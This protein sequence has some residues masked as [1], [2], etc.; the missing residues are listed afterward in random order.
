MASS[1]I[2]VEKLVITFLVDNTIE[3]MSKLPPGFT[4]EMRQHLVD[5]KPVIDPL[6]GVPI[7]D[8]ENF[9]CGAHGFSALIVR[10]L[11]LFDTGP[12]SKS[13]VRNIASMQV[14]VD[15]ISRIVLSHWHSDHSG[16]LLSYLALRSTPVVVDVHPVR[17]VARGIAP[18]GQGGKVLC[19]IPADPTF[20]EMEARNAVIEKHTEGHAV[21][22]GTVYVSG[23]IP[24]V[25]SFETGLLGAVTWS[26]EQGSWFQDEQI[27]DERYAAI[28]VLGKGLVIFSA[29]SHA[30]IVNVC[31]DALAKF[32]RPI[33][34]VI[35][36]L[37]LAGPEL[38]SR[39]AP[40][41]KFISR[42]LR[43]A[44]MYVLPMH[45]TGFQAKV[46]LE[47]ELGEG[48]VP[49]GVGMKVVVE[50]AKEGVMSGPPNTRK[51]GWDM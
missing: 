18:P 17:P 34:M 51:S 2:P 44:P 49:A 7:A 32:S 4:H 16:G 14:P 38:A 37:H 45:C 19:R 30:G 12:D 47:H 36:G 13:L 27:K 20:E 39:I 43:P 9:C 28:D 22:G 46:A 26:L 41:V 25:T 23:E 10:P 40:T 15:E 29:C 33:Y 1:I 48:I 35:G 24:R 50:G 8:I 42:E 5:Q 21:A 6:T 11:T 31:K 3:W